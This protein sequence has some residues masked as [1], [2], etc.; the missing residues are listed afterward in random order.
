MRKIAIFASGSGSNAEK[1]MERFQSHPDIR[2]DLVVTNKMDAGVLKIAQKFNIKTLVLDKDRFFRGD[3][4]VGLLMEEGIHFIVLA[5]FLW[6]VPHNLIKAFPEKIINIHPALLPAYGG[7]GM[8]GIHVHSAVIAHHETQ[9]GI[10]IH[11]VDEQYD[12]GASIFQATCS[13]SPEDNPESLAAKVLQLEHLH[14]PR[15]VEETVLMQIPR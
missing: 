8:F 13:V 2:V 6:K 4:Y 1:I 5:G 14:F 12:H 3:S 9:S 10:T 15:V 7:K 11:F